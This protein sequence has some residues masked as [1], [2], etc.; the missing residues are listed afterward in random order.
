MQNKFDRGSAEHA[1]FRIDDLE[2]D[3]K[4]MQ[5]SIASIADSTKK[6][7]THN[8][9]IKYTLIGGI[10]FYIMENIGLLQAIKIIS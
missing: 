2:K 6:T 8:M 7:A 5:E 10:G 4:L 3:F 9:I 1:H